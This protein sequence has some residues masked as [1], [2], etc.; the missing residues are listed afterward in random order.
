MA[1]RSLT[2]YGLAKK[3]GL[4]YPTIWRCIRRDR[5]APASLLMALIGVG[6]DLRGVV[7]DPSPTA[8]PPTDTAV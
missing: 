4:D 8:P 5:G 6:I 2:I 1:E 7:V 3:Y